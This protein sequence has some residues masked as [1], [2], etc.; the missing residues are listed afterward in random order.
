[1]SDTFESSSLQLSKSIF[2]DAKAL[3]DCVKVNDDADTTEE[4]LVAVARALAT[5]THQLISLVNGPVAQPESPTLAEEY[6]LTAA[7]DVRGGVLEFVQA[8]RSAASN[9]L[10]FLSQQTVDNRFKYLVTVIKS[11]V[12][13]VESVESETSERKTVARSATLAPASRVAATSD[14]NSQRSATLTPD[15]AGSSGGGG[16]GGG[17]GN[18]SVAASSNAAATSN[19]ATAKRE[20]EALR[21]ATATLDRVLFDVDS[22]E[23]TTIV[24]TTAKQAVQVRMH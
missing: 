20:V 13:A 12:S 2:V 19:K 11:V 1:M 10:D 15:R 6:L 21:K 7:R 3:M 17:G 16:G 22:R 4:R 23:R 5:T 18:G 14:R 8:V 9:P 24:S